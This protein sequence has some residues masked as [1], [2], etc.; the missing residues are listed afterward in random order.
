MNRYILLPYLIYGLGLIVALQPSYIHPDEHFQSLE[1]LVQ[2][3]WH[4]K[5]TIPWEFT[6]TDAARSYVP[7]YLTYGPLFSLLRYVLHVN[8][9]MWI[10]YCARV[11]NLI[12]YIITFKWS[13]PYLVPNCESSL[14]ISSKAELLMMTSYVTWSYQTHTFSNSIETNLLLIVLS[15]L[16]ILLS[17]MSEKKNY[18][19]VRVSL[20][21]G[22]LI[23]LGIFNR[24]TFPAFIML[25]FLKLFF[26]FYRHKSH[27]SSFLVL[28]LSIL[29]T[30]SLC[31]L[32]DTA[33]Y[34]SNEWVITPWNNLKYNFDI[35][36]LESHGLH[37]WY[38]HILVN[39]PQ[40]LGPM[41][42]FLPLILLKTSTTIPTLSIMSSMVTLSYFKHQEFRF[43]TPLVPLLLI[44]LAACIPNSIQQSSFKRS[45][46]RLLWVLFNI[47]FAVIVGVFHQS[48]VIQSLSNFSSPSTL[49][50]ITTHLWWKTYSPPTWLYMNSNLTV[51]TLADKSLIEFETTTDHV[52]DL[53]G[54]DLTTLELI[55]WDFLKHT[56]QV[57]LFVPKSVVKQLNPLMPIFKFD[58]TMFVGSHLDLDH[59]EFG[60][61]DTFSVGL[62]VYNVS[63]L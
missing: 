17:K 47:I 5:G 11:Q 45:V 8:N 4:I 15:L 53:Q 30:T 63:L 60:D 10:L 46:I 21:L 18:S 54:C 43:L 36:N 56:D 19:Q 44:Q 62:F 50:P 42:I 57:K 16:Q 31:I 41:I 13:L 23:S 9:P 6:P 33:I 52:V 51:S 28:S 32:L 39:L 22:G 49:E 3:F 59:L 38:T 2:K 40:L 27:W 25:P 55:M 20:L 12:L 14:D 7:L 24:M 26:R 29:L 61:W 1:I 34:E 58:E 48:G 35:S 37:P